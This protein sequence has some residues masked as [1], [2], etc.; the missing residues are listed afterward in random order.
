[1]AGIDSYRDAIFGIESSGRYNLLGPVTRDGDRAYGKYQ[2][3]GK[4]VGPWT[5]E[6][7]G[8]E[9]SPQEFAADPAAQDAVFNAKFGGYVSKYGPEGAARAWFAGEGGMNDP[10]RKDVLGTS[11]AQYARKFNTAIGAPQGGS[12]MN[13]LL[14]MQNEQTQEQPQQGG[15]L[16]GLFNDPGKMAALQ[17][18]MSGINPFSKGNEMEPFIRAAQ[19]RQTQDYNRKRDE[20]DYGLR[21]KQFQFSRQDREEDNKRADARLKFE[22]DQ[23]AMSPA[24]KAAR[25]LLGPDVKSD[26]PRYREFMKNYYK[27]QGEGYTKV[28]VEDGSGNKITVFQDKHGNFKRPEELIPG[29]TGSNPA[30]PYATGK[31]NNE[32]GKAGNYA[33]RMATA[34]KQIT[35]LETINDSATGFVGGAAANVNIP[36][37]GPLRDTTAYNSA[38]SPERQKFIQAQRNFVNAVL[39]RESGAAISPSE[40]ENAARQYFPQPGDSAA[41]IEQKRQNRVEATQGLMREAGSN[42]RPPKEF[43][44]STRKDAGGWTEVDGVKIR[45]KQ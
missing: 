18:L 9:M 34:H 29:Y 23:A 3:M 44:D 38:A 20:R 33:D 43:M 26:D 28:D 41:V 1:M 27:L 2:I 22:Q 11:V 39:R 8:R 32:Q 45:K 31:F 13:P 10:N 35:E 21:E 12:Q 19:L 25:D 42:Y 4:N 5:R 37:V 16:G 40:F 6:V 30:N 17:L 36:G 14:L 15:L 7:L 24:V